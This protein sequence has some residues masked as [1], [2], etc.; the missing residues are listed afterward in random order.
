MHIEWLLSYLYHV[1]D[2]TVYR[3]RESTQN[4]CILLSDTNKG[5]CVVE[6]HES[7]DHIQVLVL[8]ASKA[9]RVLCD[10]VLLPVCDVLGV[11]R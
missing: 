8:S 6:T 9:H 4:M 7:V 10:R 2:Y 11:I 3:Q 5:V 1:P